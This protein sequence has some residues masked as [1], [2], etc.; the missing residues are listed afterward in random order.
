MCLVVWV[1]VVR[2]VVLVGILIPIV[3]RVA[4][5]GCDFFSGR[6]LAYTP[7]FSF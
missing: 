3:F 5:L 2:V 4:E 6:V 1:P 7:I